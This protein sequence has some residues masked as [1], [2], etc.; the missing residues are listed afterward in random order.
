[1]LAE[2]MPTAA[3][4]ELVQEPSPGAL[5]AG[6]HVTACWLPDSLES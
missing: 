3:L 6:L 5:G 1:M 4:A 2:Q